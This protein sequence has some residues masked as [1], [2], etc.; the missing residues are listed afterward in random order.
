MTEPTTSPTHIFLFGAPRSGTTWLQNL[1]GS[2]P[3]VVTPQESNLFNYYVAPWRREWLR[4]LGSSADEWQMHRHN[5]LSAI[6]TAEEFD[7]LLGQ[8]VQRVYA[9]ALALKPSATVVVDK[10]P[11]YTLCGPL[12]RHYLPDARLIHLIRDGRDVAASMIRASKG[13]GN[14]WSPSRVDDA[15]SLWRSNVEAGR[16]MA[17]PGYLEL[18]FEE[19]RSVRGA[20]VLRNTF[21]FCGLDVSPEVC[22][23]V[24]E[25]FSLEQGSAP[26]PSSISWGGEVLRRLGSPP[27]EPVDF[28]GAGKVGGWREQ[29]DSYDRWL[30]DR[31]AGQLLVDLGYE[32]DHSRT[33]PRMVSRVAFH[34]WSVVARWLLLTRRGSAKTIRTLPALR[35]ETPEVGGLAPLPT[36]PTRRRS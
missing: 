17:G 31:E 15:A 7:G 4:G 14:D 19:L 22:R 35:R 10:V 3:E 30:F 5:G 25:Q 6:L 18:R 36:A 8:V 13:F 33:R 24:L 34:A 20:E 26:P 29:L 12:I 2:R 28:F 27:D 23:D 21:A 32:R 9:A 16:E 1:L 11:G